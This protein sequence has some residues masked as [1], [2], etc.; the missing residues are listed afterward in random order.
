MR[1][2]PFVVLLIV[3]LLGTVLWLPISWEGRWY[4]VLLN[5]GHGVVFA[6]VAVLCHRVLGAIPGLTAW[7][8][9]LAAFVAAVVLGAAV[10]V[11]QIP[12]GRDADLGD[13]GRDALGAWIGLALLAACDGRRARSVRA[14]A[15]FSV[16]VPLFLLAVPVGESVTAYARRADAF[17]VLADFSTAQNEYF[18]QAT[19]AV[20]EW[21][22]LPAPWSQAPGE[23]ALR[24]EIVGGPYSGI[25][26]FEPVADWTAY[27]ELVLDL[28]HPG[29]EPLALM[30][31]V[32]D[33]AHDH[34]Y[35]DRYNG[36]VTL[37]PAQRSVIAIP[38]SEIERGPRD[39]RLDLT[40]VAD[41]ML[42][43]SLAEAPD[44]LGREWFVSRI[45]LR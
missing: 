40:S 27:R 8:R 12:I 17:P 21:R 19:E 28:T 24:V 32:H 37:P 15:A 23:R 38:L 3:A 18:V 4:P 39:R 35:E 22:T 41:L 29:A 5:T 13:I 9:L 20:T 6:M 31:R 25:D 14:A 45:W 44:A 2:P 30:L 43:V 11:L 26:F 1:A 16:A 42:F 34:R 10:E 7:P 36:S 33:A